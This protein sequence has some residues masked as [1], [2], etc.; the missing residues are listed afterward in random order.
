MRHLLG[1][2]L[3]F[4]WAAA[5]ALLAMACVFGNAAGAEAAL[6][7]L[8]ITV[9]QGS[10]VAGES[11]ATSGVLSVV[12]ALVATLFLWAFLTLFL[13]DPVERGDP[14]EVTRM[15]FAAAAGVLSLVLVLGAVQADAGVFPVIAAVLAAITTSYL[16]IQAERWAALL[17]YSPEEEDVQA[18][19]RSMAAG[20]AHGA[21]LSRISGRSDARGNA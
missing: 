2:F 8:G 17:T 18:I 14:D 3:T 11:F 19:A 21:T 9:Q 10:G 13:G 4:H 20:A 1:S 15:A 5:F 6:D 7:M 12:F 16:A